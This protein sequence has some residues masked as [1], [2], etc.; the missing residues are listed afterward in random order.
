MYNNLLNYFE[1]NC[2]IANMYMKN[3]CI[4]WYLTL[5]FIVADVCALRYI[6][7]G[8]REFIII[9]LSVIAILISF[10]INFINNTFDEMK[11]E[12]NNKEVRF[13]WLSIL[14]REKFN[15]FYYEFQCKRLSNYCKENKITKEDIV[16]MQKYVD[17]DLQNKYPKDT[18]FSNF[19]IVIVPSIIS[20]ATVYL[21]N[22][23]IKDLNQIIALFLSYILSAF[24]VFLVIYFV[25]NLRGLFVN[26]RRNLLELKDILRN[27]E[28]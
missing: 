18:T 9:F 27:I 14:N 23:D 12:L 26:S 28:I 24:I 19:F 1:N 20:I 17:E 8:T 10:F 6:L 5:I 3:N 4:K 16:T 15:P 11:E 7:N 25:K 2:C 13:N 22:N 21:T